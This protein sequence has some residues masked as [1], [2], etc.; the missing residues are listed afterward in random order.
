M[1]DLAVN[2]VSVPHLHISSSCVLCLT[3]AGIC[4][5]CWMIISGN[6]VVRFGIW[7]GRCI[8]GYA[9]VLIHSLSGAN[10][11]KT[12]TIFHFPGINH[13]FRRFARGSF[14]VC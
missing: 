4:I 3:I 5:I 14:V 10:N 7:F 11:C 13:E 2:L 6:C 12:D 1:S 9:I 8:V